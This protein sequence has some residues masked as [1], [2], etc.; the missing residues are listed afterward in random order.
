MTLILKP[1]LG[2]VFVA[3]AYSTFAATAQPSIDVKEDAMQ[4]KSDKASL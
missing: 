3:L 2:A 4:L 1:L